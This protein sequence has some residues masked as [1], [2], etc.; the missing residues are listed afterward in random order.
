MRFLFSL[1]LS[2]FVLFS[3]AQADS[4]RII[5][6]LGHQF[7]TDVPEAYLRYMGQPFYH[8]LQPVVGASVASNGSGYVGV[9]AAFT[10]HPRSG[11]YLLRVSSMA[12]VYRQGSGADLGGPIQFRTAFEVG[13]RQRSGTEFGIG[14]DHRSNAGI[15]KSNP[16]LDTAYLFFSMPLR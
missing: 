11:P 13:H 2:I 12:G 3:A 4:P 7:N 8:S 14:F 16:G 9:G 15:Y 10:W 6:S 1:G 5:G